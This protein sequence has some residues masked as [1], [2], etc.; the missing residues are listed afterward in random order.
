MPVIVA[1]QEFA[2]EPDVLADMLQQRPE[3]WLTTFVRLAC[4]DGETEGIKAHP[5]LAGMPADPRPTTVVTVGEPRF[6]QSGTAL[7]PLRWIAIGYRAVARAFSG[8]IELRPMDGHT[9]VSLSGMVK[10]EHGTS[11]EAKRA[12]RIA[13]E[14][15]LRSLLA[16]LASAV[17]AAMVPGSVTPAGPGA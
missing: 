6:D 16:N 17:A 7:F 14:V 9:V 12:S 4:H 15:V 13:A 2:C 8:T 11:F 5:E 3:E 1:R 10:G